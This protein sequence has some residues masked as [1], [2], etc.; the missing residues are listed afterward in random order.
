MQRSQSRKCSILL[1]FNTL[2]K[3]QVSS[4]PE[5]VFTNSEQK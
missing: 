5:A 1:I 4:D 2:A 3:R